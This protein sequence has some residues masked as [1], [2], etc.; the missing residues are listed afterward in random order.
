MTKMRI[1]LNLLVLIT[2]ALIAACG[3]CGEANALSSGGQMPE[4]QKV[5]VEGGGSY[6][7]VNAPALA[8][9]LK[10]KDF[11][12]IN[13]HIPYEGEI[14]KTDLFIPYNEIEENM[15]KL[16]VYKDAKIFLYC[17]TD[18]MSII[19]ARMLV[20]LGYTNIWHLKG[21]MNAWR[22][23]GYPLGDKKGGIK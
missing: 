20:K 9:M 21:G 4:T 5:S 18:R 7:D 10:N 8:M 14:E 1:F 16:P 19:V 11:L 23:A 6:T 3:I 17:R 13:V 12:L 15:H 22:Q 2:L